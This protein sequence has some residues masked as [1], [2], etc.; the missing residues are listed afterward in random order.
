MIP[1]LHKL[2]ILMV[3]QLDEASPNKLHNDLS[4]MRKKMKLKEV[5]NPSLEEVQ[6]WIHSG[7]DDADG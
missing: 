2:G 7:P 1:I 3:T 5:K 6:G 4:G